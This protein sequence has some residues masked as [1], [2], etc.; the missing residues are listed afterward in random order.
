MKLIVLET[1]Q[2][3]VF[4]RTQKS[5]TKFAIGLLIRKIKKKN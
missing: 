1:S 2:K 5:A 3:L 4:S